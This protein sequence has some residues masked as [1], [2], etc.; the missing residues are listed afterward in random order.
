M[1]TRSS[2][3][4]TLL[5]AAVVYPA[6]AQ[7]DQERAQEFFREAQAA[8]DRDGGR[9]WG[10]SICAPMVVGDAPTQTFAASRR[11]P[12]ARRSCIK[13]SKIRFLARN[14]APCGQSSSR[15]RLA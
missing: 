1:R 11:P 6:Q 4:L 8:C 14:R 12:D 3:V 15:S 7:V 13:M 2:Y 9:L 5:S 10:V